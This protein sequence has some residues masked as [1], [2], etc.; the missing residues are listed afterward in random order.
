MEVF[1]VFKTPKFSKRG[2]TR[3]EALRAS[4]G[5]G[6]AYRLSGQVLQIGTHH[7][8]RVGQYAEVQNE[9][10]NHPNIIKR[11]IRGKAAGGVSRVTDAKVV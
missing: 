8:T 10:K 3:A 4:R 9:F 5:A 7:A 2:A 6:S 11:V 1:E